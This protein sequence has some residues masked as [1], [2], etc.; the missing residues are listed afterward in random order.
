MIN[1]TENEIYPGHKCSNANIF[2]RENSILGLS[3]P[4]DA[5]FLDIFILLSMRK[6]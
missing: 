6:V 4:E 3:E 1:S 5:E 2:Q